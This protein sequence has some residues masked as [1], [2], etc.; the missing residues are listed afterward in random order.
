MRGAGVEGRELFGVCNFVVELGTQNIGFAEVRGL[1]CELDYRGEQAGFRVTP[2][3]LRRAVGSDLTIWSWVQGNRAGATEPRTVR[4]TLL[5]GRHS[6][7]C[8]WELHGARPLAWVGP[9]LDASAADELA[10]EELVI[11][12]ENIEYTPASVSETDP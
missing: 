4:I 3:T 9:R 6:P 7:V 11:V 5:D 8:T 10:M 12:A 1:G 2:V